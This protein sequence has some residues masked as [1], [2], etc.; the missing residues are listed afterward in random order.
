MLERKTR[1]R[2]TNMH[3]RRRAIRHALQITA[4]ALTLFMMSRAFAAQIVTVLYAG[5]LGLMERSIGP[6]FK[7][8][9]GNEFRGHTG[10]SQELAKEVKEGALQGDVFISADPKVNALLSGP[11]NADRVKWYVTFAESPLVLGVSPSSRFAAGAKGKSWDEVLMQPGVKIGRTDPAKDPKGALTVEFLKKA[12]KPELAKSV[13]EHS[14]VLPEEALVKKIQTGELDVG[15]FYSVETTDAGLTAIDLPA[16]I[17]PKAIYALTILQNAPSPDGAQKFILFLLGSKGLALL[18]EHGLSLTGLQLTGA[19]AS[20]PQAIR[21][22][23]Q[24]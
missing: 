22:L 8:Q 14:S 4:L 6:A 5:S 11:T 12:D 24:K 10:G 19:D 20:V 15:F 23:V 13:L 18:K 16:G 21:A 7:Q 2:E 17:T 3:Y 1:R 9:T